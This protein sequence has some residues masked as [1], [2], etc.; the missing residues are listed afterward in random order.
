MPEPVTWYDVLGANPG[1][2]AVTLRRGYD[3]RVLLLR[4]YSRGTVTAPVTPPADSEPR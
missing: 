2:S 1:A 4:A 3:E